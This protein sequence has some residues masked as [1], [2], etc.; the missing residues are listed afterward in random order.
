MLK[1][2]RERVERKLEKGSRVY[3]HYYSQLTKSY[4]AFGS[5]CD[6]DKVNPPGS[7]HILKEENTRH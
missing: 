7:D 2:E 5:T 1:R 6:P 3:I 4:S